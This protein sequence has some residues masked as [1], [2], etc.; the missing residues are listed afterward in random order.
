[1]K[2][3]N[4]RTLLLI[5]LF[6]FLPNLLKAQGLDLFDE[7]RVILWEIQ[8]LNELRLSSG[9][10]AITEQAF[11]E[12]FIGSQLFASY[13]IDIATVK[14]QAK[15]RPGGYNLKN[16]C[17]VIGNRADYILSPSFKLTS[18]SLRSD[19]KQLIFT[20]SLIRVASASEVVS[21]DI[22]INLS[23]EEN[24]RG[25]IKQLIRQL[26]GENI[27]TQNQTSYQSGYNSN[28]YNNSYTP[29]NYSNNQS[30]G[31][32]QQ[33]TRGTIN[34][35][36]YVDL[37]L[38]VKW[39]T[40]NIG[41]NF[42]DNPGKLYAWGE[43]S[44]KGSYTSSNSRTYGENM[45]DIAGDSR[46]DVARASW[47]GTW[48]LPTKEEF[49]ELINCCTWEWTKQNGVNGYKVTSKKNGNSIFLPAAGY[50]IESSL[51]YAGSVGNYW[52]SSPYGSNFAYYLYFHSLGYRVDWNGRRYGHSVR[53]VCP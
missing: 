8:D 46:Y 44:I 10:K 2:Y 27:S 22:R 35:H 26:L 48:R 47:G 29:N 4:L 6:F 18:T 36:E 37:G 31:Y 9:L 30:Y 42:P 5:T 33:Q 40:C 49:E 19:D 7:Q 50:R 51:D 11:E 12:A 21:D 16:L 25:G 24:V 13:K 45:G 43:T 41:A 28:S 14:A 52:S 34:G 39:A 20:A 32:G 1:M 15:A 17:A 53:A 38:S 3:K 23:S